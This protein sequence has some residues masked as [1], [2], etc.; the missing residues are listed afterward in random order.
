[1]YFVYFQTVWCTAKLFIPSHHWIKVSEVGN[2]TKYIVVTILF[3]LALLF[4]SLFII[5]F[6]VSFINT[7]DSFVIPIGGERVT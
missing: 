5:H 4:F 2:Y 7:P 3:V 1:M 6:E